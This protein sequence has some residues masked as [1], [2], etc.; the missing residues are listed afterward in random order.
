MPANLTPEFLAARERYYRASTPQERL[1]ALQE[2]LRTIP[3]H[4][5]TDKMQADIKRRISRLKDDLQQQ[6][7]SGK[8]QPFWIIDRQGAGRLVLVGPANVGKSAFM[9]ATTNATPEVAPYP[10]T[11]QQP[12]PGMVPY[13]NVQFQLID[14]PPFVP[15]HPG[16]MLEVI[17]TAD[18]IM[19]MQDL[20][21]D[22]ILEKT[23]STLGLLLD[24]GLNLVPPGLRAADHP[25]DLE[26]ADDELF[27]DPN[28]RKAIIVAN[29]LDADGAEER[30]LMLQE[31]C[32]SRNIELPLHAISAQENIN[33]AEL[34]A[35]IF[36]YLDIVRI[37]TKAPGQKPDFSEPTVV[38]RGT[39][40]IEAA[41]LIHKDFVEQLKYA[42]VWGKKTFDGQRVPSDYI[43]EDEDIVEFHI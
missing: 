35:D 21:D 5:G 13:Q 23:D 15:G 37:Y 22:D 40:I 42:R 36:E 34:K 11:T 14:M 3:K 31:L 41:G 26:I 1:K 7:R 25:A 9:R 8:S 30:L 18:I 12:L 16:W 6:A 32:A 39:T 43:L 24:A 10:Y 33:I 38:P 27:Q 29:K 20:G 17:R 2:M 19:I 28:L 4:K